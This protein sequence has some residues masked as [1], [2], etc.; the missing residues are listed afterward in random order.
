MNILRDQIRKTKIRNGFRF[1]L[2][3][4]E[5]RE[6][7]QLIV[8]QRQLGVDRLELSTC[9]AICRLR[10]VAPGHLRLAL[11]D[12]SSSRHR[13]VDDPTSVRAVGHGDR[14]RLCFLR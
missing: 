11:S 4:R 2:D 13:S 1:Q 8:P 14:G 6:S 12:P 9:A 7:R 5:R 3:E 10:R